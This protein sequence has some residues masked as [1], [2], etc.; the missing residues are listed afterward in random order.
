MPDGSRHDPAGYETDFYGWTQTQAARLRELG[1][2]G[3]NQDIDWENVA[4][5][6]ESLGRSDKRQI[7]SRLETILEHLLKLTFS[8]A[9]QPRTAWIRTVRRERKLVAR[10]LKESPSLR[11]QVATLIEEYADLARDSAASSL[12][13]Y[14]EIEA[15]ALVEAGLGGD[16]VDRVLDEDFIPYPDRRLSGL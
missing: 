8:T 5:E 15:A 6:I 1:A 10:L 7:A 3:G 2:R 14:G 11:P 4:E 16:L 9:A 12:A 13:E